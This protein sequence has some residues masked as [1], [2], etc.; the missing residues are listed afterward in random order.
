MFSS[1]SWTYTHLSASAGRV[2][3]RWGA[4]KA[5]PAALAVWSF[6]GMM[7]G[8]STAFSGLLASRLVLGAGEAVTYPAGARIIRDWVPRDERG[9][10]QAL[11]SS[12]QM[13]GP[14]FGAVFVGW[15][16]DRFG[17]QMSFIIS[18]AVG[19]VLAAMWALVYR[20]PEDTSWLT[21][22]ERAQIL[23]GRDVTVARPGDAPQTGSV[24]MKFLR[25]PDGVGAGFCPGLWNLHAV[26]FRQLAA[27]PTFRRRAVSAS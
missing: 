2:V 11:M 5:L 7:T 26:P 21:E 13:F 20:N 3:D 9:F 14:A 18:G 27:D 25:S 12:G 1:F 10:A 22:A 4:Q 8:L 6:G 16:I 19:F 23:A 24:L 17:W 15:L